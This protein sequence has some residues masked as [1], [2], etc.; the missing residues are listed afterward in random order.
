LINFIFS[1][2]FWQGLIGGAIIENVG[3]D[4]IRPYKN[5]LHSHRTANL[6]KIIAISITITPCVQN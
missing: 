2:I 6:P 5:I 1:G 4:I 3:A